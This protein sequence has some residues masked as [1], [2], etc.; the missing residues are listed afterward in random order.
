MNAV[1]QDIALNIVKTCGDVH[2]NLFITFPPRVTFDADSVV[3]SMLECIYRVSPYQSEQYSD[4]CLQLG[5]P[6]Q[7]DGREEQV[8]FF[9]APYA[10]CKYRNNVAVFAIDVTRMIGQEKSVDF[11]RLARYLAALPSMQLILYASAVEESDGIYLATAFTEAAGISLQRVCVP[12]LNSRQL[13]TLIENQA[14]GAGVSCTPYQPYIAAYIEESGD[15]N[16]KQACR[17]AEE[18][19]RAAHKAEAG[20]I[21]QKVVEA[22]ANELSATLYDPMRKIGFI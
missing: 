15:M 16:E 2:G 13:L 18:L 12:P 21:S 20:D 1:I 11:V 10:A 17:F 4:I 6:L 5:F 7:E 19:V 3:H 22:A 14:E 8:K 9:D